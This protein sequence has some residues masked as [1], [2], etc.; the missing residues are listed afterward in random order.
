MWFFF[1]AY[2][3][4]KRY[5]ILY[6]F[7]FVQIAG[8]Q[9]HA[10]SVILIVVYIRT[11]MASVLSANCCV[12]NETDANNLES[13]TS[14]LAFL[15]LAI[16]VCVS[17]G[18]PLNLFVAGVIIVK[19][20]LHKPRHIF[21]L[22]VTFSNLFALAV[23]LNEL[24]VRLVPDNKL[25]C[26]TFVLLVGTPYATLLFNL[27]LGLMDRYVAITYPIVHKNHVTVGRILTVQFLG[28]L[29]I[30]VLFKL[31]YFLDGS[32]VNISCRQHQPHG[33]IIVF[34]L[35]T[36]ILLCLVTQIVVYV[37]TR[38]HFILQREGQCQPLSSR[39]ELSFS[40]NRLNRLD[41]IEETS[42]HPQVNSGV[43]HELDI[44]VHVNRE[45]ISKLEL[46]A[47]MTLVQ[48]V[49]S[50]LLISSPIF[51][52][53]L[54]VLFCNQFYDDCTAVTWMIPYFRELILVHTIYNPIM[55]IYRSHEL[56]TVGY[57]CFFL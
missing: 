35:T 32:L 14:M 39:A 43:R 29:F 3:S 49:T 8:A 17:I 46:E 45:T 47:T 7:T 31:S 54:S 20:N 18:I 33:K 28:F 38:A 27:L 36:L 34:T 24:F 4:R 22:G 13:T 56:S 1:K 9:V 25:T 12:S 10:P 37:K 55:Y 16:V 44:A 41:G 50:L 48:G 11:E 5:A 42:M 51:I 6:R 23:S 57:K 53:S 30:S 19:R 15:P 21:W 2:G 52:V 40:N 26:W